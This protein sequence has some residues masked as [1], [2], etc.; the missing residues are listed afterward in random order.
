M[1]F[2]AN[3]PELEVLGRFAADCD[4][5]CEGVDG[6]VLSI[7]NDFFLAWFV[8]SEKEVAPKIADLGRLDVVEPAGGPDEG[9]D[10]SRANGL[11]RVFPLSIDM[12]KE[13]EL[14][15]GMWQRGLLHRGAC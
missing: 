13:T 11:R 14:L 8:A 1:N 9:K 10:A 4:L 6:G 15:L 7:E 5:A 3:V 12:A 2:G